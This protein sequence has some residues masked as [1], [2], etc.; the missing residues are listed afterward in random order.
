MKDLLKGFG[1]L[2]ASVVI[3]GNII[4]HN[5]EEVIL[6]ISYPQHP[7]AGE[8]IPQPERAVFTCNI[9]A[10]NMSGVSLFYNNGY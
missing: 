7:H 6:G 5:P 4:C 2:A 1:Y 8:R 3:T 10:T 9:S